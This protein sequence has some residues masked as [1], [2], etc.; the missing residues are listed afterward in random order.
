M[1]IMDSGSKDIDKNIK[2][3]VRI[4]QDTDEICQDKVQ[5]SERVILR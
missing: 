1:W 3:G 4:C 2:N 5:F